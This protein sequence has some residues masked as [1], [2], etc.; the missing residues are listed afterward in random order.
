LLLKGQVIVEDGSAVPVE[1]FSRPPGGP[2]MSVLH[3]GGNSGSVQPDGSFA[4]GWSNVTAPAQ[5]ALNALP[6]GYVLKS[7]T[8]AGRD[9]GTTP[10]LIDAKSSALLLLTLG[11]QPVSTL[12]RVVAR[13]K[14]LNIPA[15]FKATTL[16]LTSLNPAGPTVAAPLQ[17]GGFFELPDT[18]IGAY[19]VG[20]RAAQGNAHLTS[21][22]T[23]IRGTE[24]EKTID[25]RSNPFPESEAKVRSPFIGGRTTTITGVVTQKLTP[26]SVRDPRYSPTL[27]PD[28]SAYFRMDVKDERTGA[29]SPWAVYVEEDW[30]VPRIIVGEALTVPGATAADGT[31]RFSADPF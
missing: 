10:V 19:R 14:V 26:I 5:F 13:L 28:R 17:P 18:P 23:I 20:L 12:P 16:T 6:P 8:Y 3:L 15:E 11:F 1:A 21:I 30:Q 31:N 2:M 29:V 7:W 24:L 25:F 9:Y 4:L 22:V 27:P